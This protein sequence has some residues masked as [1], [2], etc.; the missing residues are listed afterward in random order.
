MLIKLSDPDNVR[1]R[2]ELIVC[3]KDR[4]S[5]SQ[6]KTAREVISCSFV[7]YKEALKTLANQESGRI[8]DSY[9]MKTRSSLLK[10]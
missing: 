1:E 5:C 3:Y 7:C 4:L 9:S 8:K 6:S 10:T 2:P